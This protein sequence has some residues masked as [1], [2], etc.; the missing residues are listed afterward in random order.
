MTMP[1]ELTVSRI[2]FDNGYMLTLFDY[3]DNPDPER[4]VSKYHHERIVT[5]LREENERLRE[6]MRGLIE[7][8]TAEFNEK[9]AGGYA[10]A[11]LSDA[12]EA[13]GEKNE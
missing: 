12:R 3:G 13:L 10:L 4:T 2:R 7:G 5:S 9:G 11:R 8:S 1:D 6:T